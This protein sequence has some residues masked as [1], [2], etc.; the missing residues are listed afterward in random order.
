MERFQKN[1]QYQNGP[2][3]SSLNPCIKNTQKNPQIFREALKNKM[4]KKIGN[5]KFGKSVGKP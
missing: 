2:P 4:K 1:L 5:K 3:K